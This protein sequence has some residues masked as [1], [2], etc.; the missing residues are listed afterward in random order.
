MLSVLLNVEALEDNEVVTIERAR[1]I[2]RIKDPKN[3]ATLEKLEAAENVRFLQSFRVKSAGGV[4][5]VLD[6]SL[7]CRCRRLHQIADKPI[8]RGQHFEGA[9]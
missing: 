2:S 3:R 1:H 6:I 8:W 5:F 4:Y 7:L 9:Q